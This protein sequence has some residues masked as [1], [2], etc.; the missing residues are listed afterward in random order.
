MKLNMFKNVAIAGL[1]VSVVVLAGCQDSDS[2]KSQAPQQSTQ[3][4]VRATNSSQNNSSGQHQPVYQ[5]SQKYGKSGHAYQRPSPH[6]TKHPEQQKLKQHHTGGFASN[7]SSSQSDK[8]G[9]GSSS[10][11]GDNNNSD[12]TNAKNQ[13]T[14]PFQTQGE[15]NLPHNTPIKS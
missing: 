14:K 10:N 7:G 4:P 1:C 12:A 9:Q 2:K 5:G 6:H 8:T 13:Q 15:G 11:G 3:V